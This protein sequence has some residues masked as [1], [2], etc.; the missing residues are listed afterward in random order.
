MTQKQLYKTIYNWKVT[1]SSD[2]LHMILIFCGAIAEAYLT[3]LQP[4]LWGQNITYL[5]LDASIHTGGALLVRPNKTFSVCSFLLPGK[6]IATTSSTSRELAATLT[7]VKTFFSD[8]FSP[9]NTPKKNI[10]IFNDNKINVTFITKTAPSSPALQERYLLFRQLIESTNSNIRFQHLPREDLVSRVS[11]KLSKMVS[12]IFRRHLL[13][14]A[15]QKLFPGFPSQV[16]FVSSPTTF[17][18][19]SPQGQAT[20]TPKILSLYQKRHGVFVFPSYTE[21]LFFRQ[22][23]T[24]F[25]MLGV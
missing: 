13:L 8:L 3:P 20:S 18:K 2:I 1:I 22:T 11:D 10:I 15:L 14:S 12:A 19:L 6:N 9:P 24:F 7:A 5:S 23:L 16:F 17:Q 21:M 4:S 25:R